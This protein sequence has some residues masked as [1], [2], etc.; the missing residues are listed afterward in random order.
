MKTKVSFK[1]IRGR[2]KLSSLLSIKDLNRGSG[3]DWLVGGGRIGEREEENRVGSRGGRG[4]EIR[5][6]GDLS[7]GGVEGIEEERVRGEEG[8]VV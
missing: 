2:T 5:V 6:E 7:G 1:I 8:G 3:G 4:L